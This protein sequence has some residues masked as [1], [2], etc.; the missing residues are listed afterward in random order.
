MAKD[1]LV[2]VNTG[3]N[4]CSHTKQTSCLV[5]LLRLIH[6]DYQWRDYVR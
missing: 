1:V 3:H 2:A 5:N 6:Q 4:K